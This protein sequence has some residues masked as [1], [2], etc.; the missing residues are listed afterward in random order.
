MEVFFAAHHFYCPTVTGKKDSRM[1]AIALEKVPT[2]YYSLYTQYVQ[3]G[4][5]L[6]SEKNGT[7]MGW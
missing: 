7:I 2:V 6:L 5:R 1:T 3:S 4:T